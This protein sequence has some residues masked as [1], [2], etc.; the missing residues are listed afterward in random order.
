MAPLWDPMRRHGALWDRYVAGI[1]PYGI[2]THPYGDAMVPYGAAMGTGCHMGQ[3]RGQVHEAATQS[4]DEAIASGCMVSHG[5]T[6][7]S[8]VLHDSAKLRALGLAA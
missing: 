6:R 5:V 4:Y 3:L 7:Y 1:G 8:M 2:V